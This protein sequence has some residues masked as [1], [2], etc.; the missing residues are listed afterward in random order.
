MQV[1]SLLSRRS[2]SADPDAAGDSTDVRSHAETEQ[3]LRQLRLVFAGLILISGSYLSEWLL[4]KGAAVGGL[5]ALVGAIILGAP[6]L[7]TSVRDLREGVVS[8]NELVSLAVLASFATG[9]YRT[10][11]VVSFFMLVGE[12]I[13]TR[14]A[15]G[16]RASIESLIQLTPT[17]ARRLASNGEE[18]EVATQHLAVGDR[19]RVRPG[20]N[21]PADGVVRIGAGSV[22][23]ATITGESLPVDRRPGDEVFAGTINLT[24]MLEVEVTRAGGDT[25]LGKVRE[26]ILAAEQ[27]RSP[28]MRLMDR[29]MGHYTPLVLTVGALV[30]VFTH[31]LDR[32][33]S[34]LVVSCP[35]AFVLATPTAMVAALSAAARLGVLVK[36]VAD[37][38]LASRINA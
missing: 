23:Q 34:V 13:E 26:L 8:I 4:P 28:F 7:W 30:W 32:V 29:Y 16:A 6:I 27:S 9:D 19:I 12:I 14:T 18:V 11:G 10:A 1:T 24:G 35:C 21:I 3:P 20:D 22:N 17:R 36:N 38:E 2:T 25:T 5:C 37:L 31:D 33:I 15:A